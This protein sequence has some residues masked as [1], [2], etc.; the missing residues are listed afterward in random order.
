MYARA[1][2]KGKKSNDTLNESAI[3]LLKINNHRFVIGLEWETIKAQRN[4]MKEVRKIGKSRNLDVVAIRDAEAIQAGFAPKSK[5]KLRGAYSLIV[6]LASLLEG[7]C[8]AV[9]PLGKNANQEEEFT[10]VGRTEK[11][12]IH[13]VSDAIYME[14]EIK[15]VVLDLKQELRGNQHDIVI[16]VYGDPSKFS[17][18]TDLLD[19]NEILKPSNI[20]KD[21]RLK[22]LRWG[23]TRNQLI[24]FTV[25]LMM[26]GVAVLFIINY[27]EEQDRLKRAAIQAMLKQQEE[28]N[29]KARYQAALDNFT[30]PWIK[31]S[32]VKNFLA[33]CEEGL[34]TIP[35]SIKGWKPATIKCSQNDI[36]VNYIR[37][38]NSAVTTEQFVKAVRDMYG[39]EP[40]FNFTQTSIAAF[41]VSHKFPA[42]G[43]DPMQNMGE[44]L[45]KVISLFQSVN[46]SASLEQVIIKDVKKNDFGEELPV[47]QWEEFTFKVETKIPPQ[48]IF[49]NGEFTG[50]RLNS[51]IYDIG[52]D[53]GSLTYKISGSVYGTRTQPQ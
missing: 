5:Q 42:N 2:K 50:V 52:Q 18:V 4:V 27:L 17:W 1:K 49:K 13:P 35:L 31:T 6:A 37:P 39:T 38:D 20:S 40:A 48:L 28:I 24:G 22:P 45:L 30:H 21:F 51:I 14:A 3:R 44:Q 26:S 29:R 25:T 19:L 43:D 7:C 12:T 53:E 9:I 33:G 15:Q 32:S 23:M 47:Q 46:I 41:S 36:S 34:K 11:G 8:I 16:P 10:L